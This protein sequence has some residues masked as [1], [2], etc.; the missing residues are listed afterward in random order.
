MTQPQKMEL[1]SLD[2]A[3]QKRE[4]LKQALGNAFPEV[5][6]EGSIDFDHL[7]RVLGEWVDPSKERFGLNWSGKAECMKVIQQPSIATL[8]PMRDESVDFDE[9]QNLFIEGDN[10]EVLK[11]L[12]KAYFGTIK[13][14][15]IDP[16]YNR[17]ADVIYPDDFADSVGNY[18]ML[19]GQ[20]DS[21]GRKLESASEVSG[22]FHTQWMNLIFP[23]LKLARTL[24]RDDGI[25]FVSIDDAEVAH[26]RLIMDEAFGAENFIAEIIWEGANKNDARQIGVCH[27]YVLVF[28]KNRERVPREWGLNKEGVEPVLREVARLNKLHGKDYQTASED[29]AGWFR[30]NK[31][32]PCFVNRRFR[33]ID[34]KGAYKEDDPTAP[35]G[36]KFQLRNP[37]T[38]SVIPLRPNRGWSF[39][40]DEFN[41]L[42][43]QGRI[44]FISETSVMV[45]RYLH[46]TDK[47]TP[48][49]VFYQPARSASERLA[50]LMGAS[51]F[52]YPKDET[53]LQKFIQIATADTQ[54]ALVL[55]FFAG[56]GT[57][58]HA[59]CV[60][61]VGLSAQCF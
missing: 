56:S 26:L 45:R 39:D 15:Y 50:T 2:V 18:K 51:V 23:R 17:D 42:V 35:G 31:A 44:T 9:T 30:A 61:V 60:L 41:S 57:T 52:E 43:K 5:F 4:E 24:L 46:E 10:L 12:Q 55:D 28:S 1:T 25:I 48:P 34:E 32:K 36:R 21:D 37:H 3:A 16:P 47:L 59:C 13:A 53:V 27:E 6:A 54:D 49:S 29:L 38:G 7:K 19:T 22:R 11:L 14:V 20:I 58:A 40:Q 8:K 33:N